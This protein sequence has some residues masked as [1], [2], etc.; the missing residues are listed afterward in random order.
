M[1]QGGG[2]SGGISMLAAPFNGAL[3]NRLPSLSCL[4]DSQWGRTEM[5]PQFFV[6]I[7]SPLAAL[8]STV[9]PVPH[10][11][12]LPHIQLSLCEPWKKGWP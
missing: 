3:L 7:S 1:R 12:D 4:D 9:A 11:V 2:V 5:D 8:V 10:V 6:L